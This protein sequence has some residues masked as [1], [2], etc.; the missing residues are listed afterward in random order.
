MYQLARC[1]LFCLLVRPTEACEGWCN[2][3]T[4][5]KPQCDTCE[6]CV[7]QRAHTCG[8]HCLNGTHVAC[9]DRKCGGCYHCLAVKPTYRAE[10]NADWKRLVPPRL[11]AWGTFWKT[12]E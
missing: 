10:A 8:G 4:C 7:Q 5:G 3:Y 1:V 11:C 2:P 6:R 9:E 12:M